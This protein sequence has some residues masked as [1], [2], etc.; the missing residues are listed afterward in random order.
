MIPLIERDIADLLESDPVFSSS[1]MTT[2]DFAWRKSTDPFASLVRTVLAQQVSTKAADSIW[3]KLQDRAPDI[4]PDIL[5]GLGF[6]DLRACGLSRQKISYIRSLCADIAEGSFDP[7]ALEG[8]SDDEVMDQITARKGFGNWSAQ[9]FLIFT[10]HRRD[11]WPVGDLGIKRGVAVYL[12]QSGLP[13]NK[14]LNEFGAR[15]KEKRTALSLLLWK[16][17]RN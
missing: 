15:F 8:M 7:D 13:D 12:G 16:L 3:N 1:E 9:M 5:F 6:D 10:L 11:I 14:A 4:T 2:P 17:R